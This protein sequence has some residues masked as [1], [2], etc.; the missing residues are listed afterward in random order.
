MT[1]TALPLWALALSAVMFFWSLAGLW[2]FYSMATI[3]PEMMAQLPQAQQDAWT[4]MPKFIWADYLLAVVAATAGATGLLL[5]KSWA[6][7]AYLVSL[8]AIIIQFGYVLLPGSC[9]VIGPIGAG[10]PE[11]EL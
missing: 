9:R 8:I 2:S 6:S 11:S 3:S 10:S 1:K 4:T 5:G 7:L